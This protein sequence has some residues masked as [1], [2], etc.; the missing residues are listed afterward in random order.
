MA[1]SLNLHVV[2]EG[3]ETAEHVEFFRAHGCSVV[4]GHYFS[5]AVPAAEFAALLETGLPEHADAPA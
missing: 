1:R 3:V 4:Q 2:A 5:P